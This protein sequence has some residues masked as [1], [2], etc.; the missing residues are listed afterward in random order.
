MNLGKAIVD[1]ATAPVRIG[2]AVADVGLGIAS[3]T[4]QV[5]QRGLGE[6]SLPSG[7]SSFAQ[8]LG[9][10]VAVERANRLARLMDDDAPLGRALAPDSPPTITQSIFPSLPS[11]DNFKSTAPSIGSIERNFTT[12]AI[13]RNSAIRSSYTF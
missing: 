5:V 7:G 9:M 12:A 8:M 6:G 10:E 11:R 2:L 3:E 4:L 13:F 1:V